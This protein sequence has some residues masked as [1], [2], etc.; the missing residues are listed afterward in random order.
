MMA[1]TI[2]QFSEVTCTM[3]GDKIKDNQKYT[4]P[5]NDVYMCKFANIKKI[6]E[7]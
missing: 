3:N 4:C 7:D 6:G 1:K 5:L 2:L